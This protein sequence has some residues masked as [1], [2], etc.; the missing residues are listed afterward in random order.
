MPV[1]VG[2]NGFGRI[3][4]NVYRAALGRRD[5][6]IVAVNDITDPP[7]LAHLLKYDS[8]L[9]NFEGDVAAEGDHLRVDGARVKVFAERDP[10][11]LPWK[12]LG[13]DIVIESTG[14]FT[15]ATKAKVHIDK[16]GARKVIISAPAK[17]ED[18]T[19][20]L[21]VN[22]ERYDPRQHHV[23]SN[24]SCTTNC[25]APVAKV[26]HDS[27][28]IEAGLMTT[29]HSYTSDQ[30]LL[31]APHS[32][33]RR[34]RAAAL[35]V[36]PT[37]TGAAKAMALAMPELKG[38]F[39]GIS[40]R[41]PTPNVS[42]VDLAVMTP[43]PGSAGTT[44]GPLPDAAPRHPNGLLAPPRIRDALP[45]SQNLVERSARVI[46]ITH[47]GRPDGQVDDAYRT[48]P[49]ADRL[50]ELIGRP[51]RHLED[52]VGRSIEAAVTAMRDGDVVMLENVRFNPG[53]TKNDPAFARQ[54][55]ALGEL[56]VNDAFGSAHRAHASTV[57]IAQYLPA[58]AG[59]LMEREI[60]TL[61][62]IMTDPP[63]PLVAIIGGSKIS[64]KI[65]VVRSLLRRVDRL[66][67]GGAM[68]CTFLKARGLEMGRSVVEDDQL[69]VA[70]SLL[71]SGATLVLPLDAVVAPEARPGVSAKTVPVDAV[72]AEMKVLDVGPMTVERFLQTCDGAAA[73]V[74]NGPL[75]VY[76]VPPFDHGTD[77]LAQGLAGSDAQTIIGGGDLVAALQKEHLAERMSF[78]S[79][80]GGATLEFLEGK[81]LPGIAVLRDKDRHD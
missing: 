54:L 8:I 76:E 48:T 35:S 68:A 31:D 19:I 73:V 15:D 80:G 37:T 16:G 47:L 50:G 41:V 39:H 9:G 11:N 44:H 58:V 17:N 69:D 62:R 1:K 14:L 70:R 4:R 43:H 65:G 40:L 29:V 72:P 12:D 79:T 30:R 34:A 56:Y 6:E 63:H 51:V 59:L 46:L 74:W 5:L 66:C 28:G 7:T 81:V 20:V 32:D 23:V 3:G 42:V 21:G 10:G 45:T 52:C 18:I 33:L 27:F 61:G 71:S 75:G 78:V 38:K 26:L 57:G 36:I 53:E 25:L 64:T 77:A 24:A 13:I 67:I 49:L 55:A 2:I 60:T 22:G